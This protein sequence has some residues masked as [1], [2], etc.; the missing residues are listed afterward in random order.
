ME[1]VS[2]HFSNIKYKDTQLEAYGWIK[3]Q[4]II[5]ILKINLLIIHCDSDLKITTKYSPLR[6]DITLFR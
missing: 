1:R 4:K 3:L 6:I 2:S 5:K